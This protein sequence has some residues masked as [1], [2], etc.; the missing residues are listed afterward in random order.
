MITVRNLKVSYGGHIALDGVSLSATRTGITAIIGANGAGKST[1]LRAILGLVRKLSGS[2]HCGD[3]DI[4]LMPTEHIVRHGVSLVPQGH[5]LF[6]GLTCRENLRLGLF[7]LREYDQFDE[8]FKQVV[9]AFP[10]LRHRMDQRAGTLSGGE[11]QMLAIGRALMQRPRVLLLDEPTLGLSPSLAR[12]LF[13]VLGTIR[14]AG[15]SILVVEEKVRAVFELATHVCVL[16]NGRVA[17]DGASAELRDDPRIQE[18]YFGHRSHSFNRG[19][20][21]SY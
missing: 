16:T 12:T 17:L 7:G 15:T 2:V 14:D 20:T 13:G 1:L 10:A 19:L 9:S 11:R 6:D 4:T 3:H 18:V 8:R 21:T 5:A